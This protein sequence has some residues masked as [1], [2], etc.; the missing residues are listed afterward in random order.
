VSL[1]SAPVA[2]DIAA[3]HS[4]QYASV[5]GTYAKHRSQSLLF[6]SAASATESSFA[7]IGFLEALNDNEASPNN[8]CYHQLRD[9]LAPIKSYDILTEVDE[10]YLYLAP[11]VTV[12]GP[13]RIHDGDAVL[14]RET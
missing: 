13:R 4:G 11:I 6:F 5:T 14:D 12:D 7:P 10:N 1:P 8:W 2:C 9:S 3:P